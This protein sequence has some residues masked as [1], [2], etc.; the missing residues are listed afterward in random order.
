MSGSYLLR[1]SGF[2]LLLAALLAAFV[3]IT[4]AVVFPTTGLYVP[5]EEL[6][7]AIWV[8]LWSLSFV[9]SVL[10][11]LGLPGFY[12]RLAH[13]TKILGLVSF[14]LAAIGNLLMLPIVFFYIVVLPLLAAKAPMV[15]KD[16]LTPGL[17][18]FGLGG[19]IT[20]CIGVILLG[21]TVLRTRG[22]PRPVG[23][24][25]IVGGL[26]NPATIGTN[27]LVTLLGVLSTLLISLSFAWSGYL[28][29]TMPQHSTMLAGAE[30]S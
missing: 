18:V 22:Y 16:V 17:A 25:L 13:Q 5:M 30:I 19:E 28:L 24:L 9:G 3:G 14:L 20:L 11:L 2:A 1:L 7:S 6:Q 29:M 4:G 15:M 12:L 26:L 10:L 21:I 23:I 27:T 8:P